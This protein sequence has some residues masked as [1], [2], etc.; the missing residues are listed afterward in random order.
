MPV[1]VGMNPVTA[2]AVELSRLHRKLL[3]CTTVEEVEAAAVI[4]ASADAKEARLAK[5]TGEEKAA[6]ALAQACWSSSST[7]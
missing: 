1:A 4:L 3:P 2:D 5:I 7:W 6:R